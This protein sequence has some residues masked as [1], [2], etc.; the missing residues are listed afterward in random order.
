LD[1]HYAR[2]NKSVTYLETLTTGKSTWSPLARTLTILRLSPALE[3]KPWQHD[4]ERWHGDI[5]RSGE[6]EIEL[7]RY[8]I[9]VLLKS[10][11]LSMANLQS[12]S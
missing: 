7:L 8:R 2:R 4:G 12:V 1:V 9:P 5:D 11:V 6:P 10:A 3:L